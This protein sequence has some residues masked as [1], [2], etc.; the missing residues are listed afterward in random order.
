MFRFQF[1]HRSRRIMFAIS[2]RAFV[3]SRHR[4]RDWARSCAGIWR[5]RNRRSP[6]EPGRVAFADIRERIGSQRWMLDA[7]CGTG[8]TS[9]SWRGDIP[10]Y[11]IVGI[12][13]SAARLAK[14]SHL[15]RSQ[16]NA[17]LARNATAS[18]SGNSPRC[19]KSALRTAIPAFSESLAQTRSDTT[20]LARASNFSGAPGAESRNIELRTNWRVYADE[21]PRRACDRRNR[22]IRFRIRRGCTT[23]AVRAKIRRV[24]SHWSGDV[25]LRNSGYDLIDG[26][27]DRIRRVHIHRF[28][29]DLQIAALRDRVAGFRHACAHDHLLEIASNFIVGPIIAHAVGKRDCRRQFVRGHAL[30][31]QRHREDRSRLSRRRTIR[32][33]VRVFF[34]LRIDRNLDDEVWS[35]RIVG[36]RRRGV[37]GRGVCKISSSGRGALP[38]RA[39]SAFAISCFTDAMV[40]ESFGNTPIRRFHN[41]IAASSF[42]LLI[43]ADAEQPQSR[44]RCRATFSSLIRSNAAT[45]FDSADPVSKGRELRHRQSLCPDRSAQGRSHA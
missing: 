25:R 41:A 11:V 28:R 26:E 33:L 6:S 3:R 31:R 18:I 45:A 15:R 29:D 19:G 23:H 24:E 30:D 12:D 21:F 7:G 17:I 38:S 39:A 32:R 44:V 22:R 36:A 9:T 27:C 2:R 14:T 34:E 43:L 37:I 5:P 10:H 42:L 8:P 1:R 35:G 20:T 16:D 13:K 4:T 40:F